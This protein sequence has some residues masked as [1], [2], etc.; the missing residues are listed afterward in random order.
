MPFLKQ[1][2]KIKIFEKLLIP[3]PFDYL[4]VTAKT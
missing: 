3:F 4:L 1:I 2:S